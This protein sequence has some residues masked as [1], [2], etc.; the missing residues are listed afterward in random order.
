VSALESTRHWNRSVPSIRH[1]AVGLMLALTSASPIAPWVHFVSHHGSDSAGHASHA[2]C[3]HVVASVADGGHA[4]CEVTSAG[5]LTADGGG[6]LALGGVRLVSVKAGGG[7]SE[8]DCVVC[9]QLFSAAALHAPSAAVVSGNHPV[10][11]YA[12]Y[13][14]PFAPSPRSGSMVVRGPPGTQI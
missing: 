11:R 14:R 6:D 8:H 10:P 12:G 4:A 1:L 7:T 3:T 5:V 2:C 9:E 13:H